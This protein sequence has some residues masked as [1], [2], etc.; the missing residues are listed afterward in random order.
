[1]DA[2]GYWDAQAE[3]FDAEPDHGLTDAAVRAAWARLLLPLLPLSAS[4]ADLGSGTGTLAVLLAGAG[5]VVSGVDV[6]PRMVAAA[7]A[8]AASA[9]VAAC[10][11]VGDA[12]A[13][14]F[15]PGT[16]DAV[17]S[18][19]VLW[20]MPDP[21]EALA[22]WVALLRPGGRLLLVDGRWS[23]GGGLSA[24]AVRDLVLR[25]R[26]EADVVPLDY[27]ALWGRPVTDERYLVA[28]TC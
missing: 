5:H 28:S 12:A 10:F 4:V 2:A 22:S 3:S 19:H 9:G 7:R 17:L 18:R 26:A 14:P 13:P 24:A 23:T 16:F 27:P 6:A 11:V 8:K 20:A 15:A 21:G 1:M 25:H